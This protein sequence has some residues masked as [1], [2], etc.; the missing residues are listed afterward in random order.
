MGSVYTS[1]RHVGTQPSRRTTDG[2]G[3]LKIPPGEAPCKGEGNLKGRAK[4]EKG[5][6]KGKD[7]SLGWM[8]NTLWSNVVVSSSHT[9]CSIQGCT[10]GERGD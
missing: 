4:G 8:I 1:I 6:E 2:G 5:E 7:G 3:R 10:I 9:V